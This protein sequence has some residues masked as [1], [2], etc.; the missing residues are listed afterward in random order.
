MYIKVS[1]ALLILFEFYSEYCITNMPEEA[2]LLKPHRKIVV[3]QAG[4]SREI[5]SD[6][7]HVKM[8]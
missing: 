7:F 6:I 8:Q 4:L 1:Q 5:F 3:Q 2:F